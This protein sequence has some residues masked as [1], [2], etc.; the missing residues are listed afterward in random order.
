MV[1]GLS[2]VVLDA[3]QQLKEFLEIILDNVIEITWKVLSCVAD[4]KF[5]K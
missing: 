3:G 4:L 5:K 2:N 1:H